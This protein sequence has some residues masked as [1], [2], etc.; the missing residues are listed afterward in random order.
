MARELHDV[1]AHCV[2]VMV[3]QTGAARRVAAQDTKAAREALGVVEDAGREALVELRRLVGVLRRET[4]E[5]EDRAAPG[6]AG[7]GALA[8][9]CRAAG[10][11]V[12]LHIRGQTGLAI[13]RSR[14]GRVPRGTGGPDERD[15]AR[16]PGF[17]GGMG[18]GR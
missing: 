4:G 16:W 6:L 12:E 10:L 13:G 18:R 7:L 9:R 11:P 1:I 17:G 8:E 2:S 15:Q 14:S 3:V 5:L